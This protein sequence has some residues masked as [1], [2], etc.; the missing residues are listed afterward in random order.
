LR[1]GTADSRPAASTKLRHFHQCKAKPKADIL[2]V[3]CNDITRSV[4]QC[5]NQ[6]WKAAFQ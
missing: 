2:E 6:H 4:S 1:N 5:R 3:R